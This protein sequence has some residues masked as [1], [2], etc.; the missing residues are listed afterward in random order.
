M[1]YVRLAASTLVLCGASA[2]AQEMASVDAHWLSSETSF[3]S[4]S[5]MPGWPS[6][7]P[8][9]GVAF[10]R[11][12]P[13]LMSEVALPASLPAT[14]VK[15]EAAQSEEAGAGGLN[16]ARPVPEPPALLMLLAGLGVLGVVISRR[17]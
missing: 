15:A 12:P 13:P 2:V 11:V 5:G 1:Q 9:G 16:D 7:S 3:A 14:A 8:L 4:A 17:Q 6:R 10:G